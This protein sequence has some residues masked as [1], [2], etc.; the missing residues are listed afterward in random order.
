MHNTIK[1]YIS[2]IRHLQSIITSH[3]LRFTVTSAHCHRAVRLMLFN[4]LSL[5]QY[6][7]MQL[8]KCVSYSQVKS[9]Q[10]NS[11]I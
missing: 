11:L 9:L 10:F 6:H 4:N 8:Y 1:F 5:R 2:L 3:Q 7:C